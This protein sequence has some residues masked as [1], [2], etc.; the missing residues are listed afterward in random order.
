[1]RIALKRE[2]VL[3]KKWWRK[4]PGLVLAGRYHDGSE[5]ARILSDGDKKALPSLSCRLPGH[6]LTYVGMTMNEMCL[7]I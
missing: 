2:K 7:K 1:M 3:D 5:T 4:Q 6:G